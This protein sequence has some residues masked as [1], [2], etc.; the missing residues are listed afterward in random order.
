VNKSFVMYYQPIF[1]V[2]EQRFTSAEALIRLFD[3]KNGMVSPA[4]FIPSAEKSGAIHQIGEFVVQDVCGFISRQNMADLGLS[5]VEINLSVVQCMRNN[6]VEKIESLLSDNHVDPKFVNFEITETATEFVHETLKNNVLA[7][8]D[9]GLEF[10]L[11]DYGTGYSNLQ[12]MVDF[13]FKLIKLDKS[14]VD[15]WEDPQMRLVIQD[16][17]RML[18]DIG[19]EIVVEGVETKEEAEW[20]SEQ[21]CDYIQGYFYARPMP[22][23]DFLTFLSEHRPE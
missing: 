2:K 3:E 14:F 13:P 5:Y 16:T 12:R 11:D 8:H 23:Q 4:I 18:K 6:T 9:H 1:S 15:Q 10:A 17:I 20:F 21:N 7:L 22:E 19:K